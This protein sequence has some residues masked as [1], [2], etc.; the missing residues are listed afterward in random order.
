[1]ASFTARPFRRVT[2]SSRYAANNIPLLMPIA[3]SYRT[4]AAV[5]GVAIAA[6]VQALAPPA[7]AGRTASHPASVTVGQDATSTAA[8]AAAVRYWTP[9][10]MAAALVADGGPSAVKKPARRERRLVKKA[11]PKPKPA[12]WLT[13]NTAGSG[14]RWTHGGARADAVGKVFFTLGDEDYVCSGTL[15]GSK[16]A[17]VVL[18]AAHCVTSGPGQAGK[19]QWATN[20]MFVPGFRDGRQPYG[21]Y[22]AR[23]FFVPPDW[24]GPEGGD[25]QYDVAF[26]QVSAATL[27]GASGAAGAAQPPPGL[28]VTFAA[29]QDAAPADRAY[30]FGYPAERPYTGLDL[31]YCAGP[32]TASGGSVRTACAM[33]AGD[34][35]GPWLASF[36]PRSGSGP[37]VAVS[38]YKVSDNLRV[39]YGAVLG[40]QARA[41][42][43]RA[44]SSAR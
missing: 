22:T 39:L 34:S 29:R 27:Y 19:V 7:G 42:Y 38:T 1:M 37:V 20:W 14:L 32:V 5:A 6:G 25:E 24:T 35:G 44:V 28:P 41:L 16:R 40:P 12:P 21:E 36:S 13:G 4:I 11:P 3:F 23:R 15:V 18:T 10:R 33:T 43:E 9:D 26:V 30:V 17:D 8:Q 31:S 2:S